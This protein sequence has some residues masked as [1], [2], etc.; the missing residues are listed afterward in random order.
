MIDPTQNP[1]GRD[2]FVHNFEIAEGL[3]PNAS[4]LAAEHNEPWPGGRTNHYYFDLNRDW[5]SLNHPETLGRVKVLQEYFPPVFVD[6]HEMGSNTTYYFAPEAIPYNP[7]LAR[8]QRESLQLFGKNNAKWFDRYGFSYFTRE[9]FDAF[10]PGYG[11]S[12]PSYYGS[13]A[14]TYE[15]ASARGLVVRRSDESVMHFRDTVRH[16]FVASIATSETAAINREQL[17]ADFYAYRQ[18]AIEEGRSE[19][20]RSYILPRRLDGNTSGRWTSWPGSWPI[21][22]WRSSRPGRTSGRAK[23]PIPQ[24][25]TSYLSSSP[26]SA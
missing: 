6:L 12:W 11:A 1:D 25:V 4:P 16:H 2:R 8:D 24:A 9:V 10:Y 14:M 18:S 23:R 7:H 5:I 3:E 15:Q 17:L 20:I 13:V 26:P 22:A 21:T 19:E